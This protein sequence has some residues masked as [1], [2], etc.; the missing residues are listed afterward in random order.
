LQPRVQYIKAE[1]QSV[2]I[3][4]DVTPDRNGGAGPAEGTTVVLKNTVAT[5]PTTSP[6]VAASP[7]HVKRD[8]R[9]TTLF[10]NSHE[11]MDIEFVR[12]PL[13][14]EGMTRGCVPYWQLALLHGTNCLATTV[15]Q[16]CVYWRNH[17]KRCRFC[18][19]ELSLINKS[20]TEFKDPE[21]L[22]EVACLA[23]KSDGVEHITLTTG[24]QPGSDKGIR[25]LALCALAIKTAT[26][27]PVHVQ[28]EPP[29]DIEVI[30]ELKESLVDTIGI[31]I[32]TFDMNILKKIAPAKYDLG[33]EHYMKAWQFSV[34]LFGA[35]Q[36]S[37]FLLAGLEER[38][39]AIFRGSE[40]L[41][42]L[43]VYPFV[44]PLRPIPGS[45]MAGA[46]PIPPSKMIRIYERVSSILRGRGL[47]AKRSKAGCVR[48]GA[49][50][51]LPDFELSAVI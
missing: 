25:H 15:A 23:Q 7:Y 42:D 44:V 37:S 19:I 35:N 46:A 2:G 16:K 20:T 6:F 12:K 22:A 34:R 28:F 27:L 30:R 31:H 45:L 24:T 50:S 29:D 13:F 43:G 26:G 41:A 18:G 47:S 9:R 51:A 21:V 4:V 1:L 8:S 40:I 17:S 3:R 10:K 14:Y 39:A 32:E 49:C 5:V 38:E 48:C 36:V 11:I 33:L